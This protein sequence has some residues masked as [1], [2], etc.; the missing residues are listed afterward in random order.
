MRNESQKWHGRI[1]IER[2]MIL[3]NRERQWTRP[4]V[5]QS[6]TFSKS[7]SKCLKKVILEKKNLQG[8]QMLLY[9]Q[10]KDSSIG[11]SLEGGPKTSQMNPMLWVPFDDKDHDTP[12]K[13]FQNVPI[14]FKIYLDISINVEGRSYTFK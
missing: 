5:E 8:A 14:A 10:T 13:D 11:K 4:V 2:W 6:L 12:V 3:E 7:K 1:D 9:K